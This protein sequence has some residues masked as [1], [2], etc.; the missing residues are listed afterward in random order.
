MI[1]KNCGIYKITSPTGKIYI[2]Q[3]KNIT[4][5]L[6]YYKLGNCK[7]QPRIHN[8]IN[9][10]GWESH[11]FDIIEYCSEEELNC[12]ERFW[13]DEFE[14]VGKNGLNAILTETDTLPR[15]LS[16]RTRKLRSD[17]SKSFIGEKN[18]FYGKVHS[19]ESK[20]KMR[21]N[22]RGRKDT[23]ERIEQKRQAMLGEKNW[24]YG[25]PK[26]QEYRDKISESHKKRALLKG[27][28]NIKAKIVLNL[29]TGIFYD[30]ISDA[31]ESIGVNPQQLRDSMNP[32]KNF[33]IK[34]DV[35]AYTENTTEEDATS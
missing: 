29:E 12:S 14:A 15:I 30:C 20:S 13:Q 19:E 8:S 2:G 31:A 32:N 9:K 33:K 34:K 11:Q 17:I 6:R 35:F 5:R 25:K 16:E 24:N 26:S 21:A 27:G 22:N 1:N 10:H 7:G 28:K 23:P 18:S 4:K 3:S